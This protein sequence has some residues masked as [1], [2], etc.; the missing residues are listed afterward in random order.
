MQD[1]VGMKSNH[2]V[3]CNMIAKTYFQLS[4][5]DMTLWTSELFLR[6]K[7]IE[8]TDRSP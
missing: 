7:S 2:K 4:F 5:E 8:P 3:K 6:Q 1:Y